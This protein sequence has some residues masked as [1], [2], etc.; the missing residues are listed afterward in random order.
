MI[1][2]P[3]CLGQGVAVLSNGVDP[4]KQV[5][6]HTCWMCAGTGEVIEHPTEKM[7]IK[8]YWNI[9]EDRV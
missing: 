5:E 3:V 4:Q 9:T 7:H 1:T 8:K 2:C 6:L